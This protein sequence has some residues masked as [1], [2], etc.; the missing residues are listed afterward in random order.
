MHRQEHDDNIPNRIRRNQ[1][2]DHGHV[3]PAL[4]QPR[5][6]RRDGVAKEDAGAEVGHHPGDDEAEGD[7]GGELH[8]GRDEDADEEEEHACLDGREKDGVD[9]LHPKGQ[10]E[11]VGDVGRHY[12]CLD[13]SPCSTHTSYVTR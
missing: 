2:L 7:L 11:D 8:D 1:R 12:A 5:P 10:L 9:D 4:A 3:H 13:V 6:L